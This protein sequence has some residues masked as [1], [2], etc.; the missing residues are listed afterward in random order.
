M[1]FMSPWVVDPVVRRF[2]LIYDITDFSAIVSVLKRSGNLVQD[3]S[4]TRI[5]RFQRRIN[6]MARSHRLKLEKYLGDGALYSGRH[7][8][9]L[10]AMAIGVQRYYQ[11]ALES[12]FP[13]DRG[14]RIALNYGQYRLLPIE[15]GASG[16]GHRYE[17]FGHGIV[18][19]SRLV[20]GKA[21]REI[22]EVKNLLLRVGYSV[23]E[24]DR[25][26]GPV[27]ARD[28]DVVDK[29]E[30]DRRFF[31]YVNQSGTLIN[32]GIVATDDFMRELDACGHIGGLFQASDDRRA[33]VA[34]RVGDSV[35]GVV[36]G[37][38]KLGPANLK[39]LGQVPIYE[40]V[41]GAGWQ[42]ERLSRIEVEGLR[43]ALKRRSVEAVGS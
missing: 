1:E 25:F 18:E 28:I 6:Q 22:D 42:L 35:D 20:T 24:V 3:T 12:G 23:S 31:S 26:F 9:K 2:G 41:D 30:E 37:A 27:L 8:E 32:E 7:P 14:L 19:L 43:E 38:R 10:L 17:F 15:G 4:Y 5:F 16:S 13:F 34:F 29:G 33:Y 36:A 40:L 11:R 39:G 21:M